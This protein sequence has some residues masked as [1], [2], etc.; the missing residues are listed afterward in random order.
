MVSSEINSSLSSAVY[1]TK[2]VSERRG[3][4][5]IESLITTAILALGL[6]AVASLFSYSTGTNYTNRQRT[7]AMLLLY[8]KME[9][10][11]STPLTSSPWIV[12]GGL[13][14][15][16]P[17]DGYFDYASISTSG[18]ITVDTTS[19]G[20]P[21]LRVWQVSGTSPRTVTVIVCTQRAGATGQ[22]MEL[23]RA[24]TMASSK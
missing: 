19:T 20:A 24:T 12:G 4:T 9:M 21:Y 1:T 13:N 3:F 10:F 23:A 5:L 2:S 15:A 7:A 22:R 6:I 14:T 11:R 18:T 8:E 16:A 17:V